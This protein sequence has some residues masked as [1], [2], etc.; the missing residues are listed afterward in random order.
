[1]TLSDRFLRAVWSLQPTAA[2]SF[3][4]TKDW[5]SGDWQDFAIDTDGEGGPSAAAK[6][7]LYF[8]PTLFSEP[9]RLRRNACHGRWLYAD[10]DEVDPETLTDIGG[11]SLTPTVA[12]ETSPN[13]YQ[14]LWLLDR[15]LSPRT[16]EKLNQRLTYFTGADKGGWSL[17][18]VLRVPGSISHKREHPFTVRLLW[19]SSLIYRAEDIAALLRDVETPDSSPAEPVPALRDLPNPQILYRKRR[20][21][22]TIRARQL[23]N[24]STVVSGDDR[25]ARLWELENELLDCGIKPVEV[26]ALVRPTVWNKYHG[27]RR[28]TAMLWREITKAKANRARTPRPRTRPTPSTVKN[29]TKRNGRV[30]N[31]TRKPE[32]I[33]FR[34]FMTKSLPKAS[35]LVEGIWSEGAHGMMAGEPKTFKTLLELDLAVSIA[36]GTPFLGRFAVPRVGPVCI[37]QEENTPGDMQDRL[38]RIASS[39]GVGPSLASNGHDAT[40]DFGKDLGIYLLNNEGFSLLDEHWMRWLERRIR[41][42]K[43]A[44]VTFD[45]LY[46]VAKGVDE[47]SASDMTPILSN[48]LRLKQ[49]Y[50]CGIQVVHHYHKPKA[51]SAKGRSAARMSGTGVFH[52]WLAS[53]I[54][55]ERMSEQDPVIKISGEHRSHGTGGAF[56]VTFDLGSPEDLHYHAE[57]ESWREDSP[58]SHDVKQELID[59]VLAAKQPTVDAVAES[60]GITANAVR[61]RAR[62]AGLPLEVKRINGRQRTTV[63]VPESMRDQQEE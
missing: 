22:M 38:M 23:L 12:W 25:S 21:R 32:F 62:R 46:L 56:K 45:P 1:V 11:V 4:S 58:A 39:R 43:P 2:Y 18:K 57:V 54:Y 16:L 5:D 30:P 61:S 41:K 33:S 59:V 34:D 19:A 44:L 3:V 13:R 53:A 51:D 17:T 24:T 37:V 6:G 26:L 63:L 60:L 29:P 9:R 28:E 20:S 40:I 36:S 42:I 50:G 49:A 31:H 14:A 7:D 35:W 55:V 52:R 10:L 27:Q 48:L 15:P 8:A 47:N